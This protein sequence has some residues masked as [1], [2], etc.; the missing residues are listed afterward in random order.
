MGLNPWSSVRTHAE[1][2]FWGLRERRIFLRVEGTLLPPGERASPFVEKV[3][4]A[5]VTRYDKIP[6]C[7]GKQ[8]KTCEIDSEKL[9]KFSHDNFLA[10]LKTESRN[11]SLLRNYQV[12][13]L[14]PEYYSNINMEILPI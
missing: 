8:S 1:F 6:F 2:Y 11:R 7:V 10:D 13:L 5:H 14:R 3:S 4:A 9:P 12:L